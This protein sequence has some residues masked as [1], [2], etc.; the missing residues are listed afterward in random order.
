M[1]KATTL[2]VLMVERLA[3]NNQP[4]Q[5]YG[6]SPQAPYDHTASPAVGG[7]G[8]SSLHGRDSTL[9]GGLGDYGRA[10]SQPAQTVQ[11]LGGSGPFGG[12]Q[13]AFARGSSYQV[14][15]SIMA[16]SKLVEMT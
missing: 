9:G 2:G 5:G 14:K 16:N 1:A 8:Q 12:M 6:M 11:P 7:F 4:H 10:G 15:V 13:D 3:C